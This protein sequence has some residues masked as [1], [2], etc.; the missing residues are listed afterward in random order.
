MRVTTQ[1]LLQLTYGPCMQSCPYDHAAVSHAFVHMTYYPEKKR[2]KETICKTPAKTKKVL[3]T[4][5]SC[6]VVPLGAFF[7]HVHRH[8]YVY[9]Y[10]YAS[11]ILH[12][13]A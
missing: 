5:P 13:C 8:A 4:S 7:L 10:M 12:A 3:W 11:P 9:M 6:N 1:Q 2:K